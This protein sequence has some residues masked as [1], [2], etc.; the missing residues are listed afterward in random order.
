MKSANVFSDIGDNFFDSND[1]LKALT[2]DDTVMAEYKGKDGFMFKSFAKLTFSANKL[3]TFKDK[4][5]GLTDRLLVLPMERRF[6]STNN[7]KKDI[8][9]EIAT[10]EELSGFALKCLQAIQ[11]VIDK[12]NFSISQKMQLATSEWIEDMD[13]LGQFIKEECLINHNAKI[14]IKDFYKTYKD[15]CEDNGIKFIETKQTITKNLKEKGFESR[16]G[17]DNKSFY[18]GIAISPNSDYSKLVIKRS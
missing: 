13:K 2:G 12:G 4:T 14:T 7:E 15:W 1:M 9:S 5:E 16:K 6:R 10:K 11:N 17:T 8:L 18:F 3:P